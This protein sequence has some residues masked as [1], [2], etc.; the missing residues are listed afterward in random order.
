MKSMTAVEIE[1]YFRPFVEA[2]DLSVLSIKAEP[3][4]EPPF[5]E[6]PL[7]NVRVSLKDANTSDVEAAMRAI[8]HSLSKDLADAV[9][10]GLYLHDPDDEDVP[11]GEALLQ[12]DNIN[13]R[14]KPEPSVLRM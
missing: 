5:D 14:L 12:F 9:R 3:V 1:T 13:I 8:A 11:E 7:V 6:L 4:D 2:T 10:P